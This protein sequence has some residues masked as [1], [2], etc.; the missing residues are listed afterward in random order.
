VDRIEFRLVESEAPG[1][2]DGQT[3]PAVEVLV[4]GAPLGFV[5]EQAGG[6]ETTPLWVSD[7]FFDGHWIGDAFV[8]RLGRPLWGEDADRAALQKNLFAPVQGGRVAVLTCTC[9]GFGCGGATACIAFEADTVTWRDFHEVSHARNRIEI[10][11]FAFARD[12]YETALADIAA[13]V[14]EAQ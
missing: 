8:G 14:S 5:W 3:E 11:P 1:S 6:T 4:N 7:A 10:G 9:G 12:Q 2:D 13:E